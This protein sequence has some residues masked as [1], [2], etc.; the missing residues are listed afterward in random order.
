MRVGLFWTGDFF[1]GVSVTPSLTISHFVHRNRHNAPYLPQ[2]SRPRRNRKSETIRSMV[3]ENIVSPRYTSI[4]PICNSILFNYTWFPTFYAAISSTR[5]SFT[6]M[7]ALWRYLPCLDALDTPS[8]P[9]WMR[10]RRHW[11]ELYQRIVCAVFAYSMKLDLRTRVNKS[12]QFIPTDTASSHSFYSRR[13]RTHWSPTTVKRRTTSTVSCPG[14][15]RWSRVNTRT[16]WCALMWPSTLTPTRY[17]YFKLSYGVLF[18][19]CGCACVCLFCRLQKNF[20]GRKKIS[21]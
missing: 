20:Q 5:C 19:L 4:A 11:G 18:I 7:Q 1:F 9:W 16:W 10:C 12:P 3:R 6:T 8:N 2:R 21:F 13:S 15:C 14:P 17:G